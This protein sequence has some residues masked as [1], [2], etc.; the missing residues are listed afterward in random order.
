MS[1]P[2]RRPVS[3]VVETLR[4]EWV[5]RVRET[6]IISIVDDDEWSR[7][8]IAKLVQSFGF[9][10]HDFPSARALLNSQLLARTACVISDIQ[11]PVLNGLQLL[12]ELRSRGH[13]MPIVFVTA[14]PDERIRAQALSRGASC[15]L[16]KPFDGDALEL[17]LATAL[18]SSG[19]NAV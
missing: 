8:G 6:N 13:N 18:K 11:M 3:I 5:N 10:A 16:T 2:A 19:T 9:I 1:F 15:V 4:H 12:D 7:I 14:F 17:C